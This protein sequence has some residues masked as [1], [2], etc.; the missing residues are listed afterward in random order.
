MA[1]SRIISPRS[2]HLWKRLTEWYGTR[3]LET[4]GELPP[5]DWCDVIDS[6]DNDAVKKGLA[7]IRTKYL[8]FPPTLPEFEAAVKPPR[9]RSANKVQTVQERL[10]AYVARNYWDMLTPAQQRG[11]WT[12]IGTTSAGKAPE[13]MR[14]D[15]GVEI[16]GVVIAADGD[17]TGYRVKVEDM[18]MSAADWG[19]PQPPADSP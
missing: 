13:G 5:P 1:K 9:A 17:S 14:E 2:K 3:I 16:T 12:Y 8:T 4:Y 11:P 7:T 18:V 19:H 15:W 6:V 10:C